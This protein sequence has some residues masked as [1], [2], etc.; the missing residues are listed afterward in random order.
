MTSPS[1]PPPSSKIPGRSSGSG[2]YLIGIV[3]LALGALGLFLWKRGSTIVVEQPQVTAPPTAATTAEALP[4]LYAP[5]PPPKIEEEPDAGAKAS[6]SG[7]P[8][9]KGPG[10]AAPG[11]G[12]CG[13][14]CDGPGSPALQAALRT[15]AQSA[16][17]CYNR[18]LRTSEAS[19][20]LVVSVQ[21]ASN[22]S[23]CSASLAEDAVHSGEISSC[24][25]GRFRG[26]TFPPPQ[27]GCATVN[28]P[29]SFAIKQ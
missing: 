4:Q 24:V 15:T 9:S 25:L 27:G 10:V 28:I 20:R 3:L 1:Q 17:G 13:G 11:P 8:S 22:G 26:H 7:Q 18:A 21:V 12:Q 23:V 6:T 29:I 2:L 14:R 5:P 19:G 16:Q